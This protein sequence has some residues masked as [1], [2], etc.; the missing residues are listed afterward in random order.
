MTRTCRVDTP[1]D[2]ETNADSSTELYSIGDFVRG[3]QPFGELLAKEGHY[4]SAKAYLL[5]AVLSTHGS[6][7]VRAY[8]TLGE[9]H[10]HLGEFEL[11][12]ECFEKADRIR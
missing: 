1:V 8:E 6:R 2:S 3:Y 4:E 7:Q 12:E 9:L 10:E 11:A 5:Q